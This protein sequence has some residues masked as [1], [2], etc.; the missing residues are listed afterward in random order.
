MNYSIEE[1]K[2]MHSSYLVI[3]FGLLFVSTC[4]CFRIVNK[5]SCIKKIY[6]GAMFIAASLYII[7]LTLSVSEFEIL[8]NTM[9]NYTT[10]EFELFDIFSLSFQTIK[11]KQQGFVHL[12]S[13]IVSF[14]VIYDAYQ[15]YKLNSG[16]KKNA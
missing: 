13:G 3:I 5:K 10:F 12:I 1:I 16:R 15:L 8:V 14:V 2:A 4:R 9:S 11:I 6:C 7:F